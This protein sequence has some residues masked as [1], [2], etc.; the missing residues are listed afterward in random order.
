MDHLLNQ[1]AESPAQ[2]QVMLLSPLVRP[3]AWGWS[4]LSYYAL[5]PFVTG[6]ARRFSENSND[7]DFLAF[8]QVDPLQPQRLPTAWVGALS[9]WIKRLE[10]APRSSRQPLIVQGDADMTVDWQHN[11]QVI[12]GKFAA[13]ELLMLPDAR[14][15]LANEIPL[16]RD[17]YFAFLTQH[18]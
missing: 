16:Y 14:H 13:P 18:L 3:R 10:A 5:R 4:M 1:G 11:L 12:R 6:I 8:L 7:P 2:G 17:Q 15:H 9:R